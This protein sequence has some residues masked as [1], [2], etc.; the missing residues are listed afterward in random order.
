MSPLAPLFVDE[1]TKRRQ[2]IASDPGTSV[3]VSANAGSG[4]THVLTER[5]VRLLLS[6]VD[7]SKILC[8]T[9]T[10]AAAAEMSARVFAR[11]GEWATMPDE[12]LAGALERLDARRPP[13]AA[14]L[15]EARQLFARALET[16]GGLKIQTI[17]AFCEAI[18]HQFP[19][20]ADVPGHFE[21][22]DDAESARLL[23]ETRKRLLTGSAH[24]PGH[25]AKNL[26]EAFAEALEVAGEFGLDK[27][28]ADIAFKRD[29]VFRHL[30]E[31]GGL[32][33]AIARLARALAIGE[34][35][36]PA[37]TLAEAL[38]CPHLDPAT[39]DVLRIATLAS[40]AA[41]DAKFADRLASFRDDK[42][43]P[44]DRF[45]AYR[46]IG[47]DSKGEVRSS[48]NR[49]VTK[50]VAEFIPDLLERVQAAGERAKAIDERRATLR[51][52][53]ASRAALTIADA[54]ERE[55]AA[56]K[57]R[58]GR[59]DFTDLIA[60]T[61]DLLLRSEA[62]AW[63]H[64]KLDQGIDHILID[65]AQD[66]S[67]RQWQ[68]M[69][70]LAE[71]FFAGTGS[72]NRRR[73]LFAV[74]DEKQS[75]YS[76]QGASPQ[77]FDDERRRVERR[78][79]EAELAFEAIQLNRSFRTVETVLSAVDQ[80][81]AD[82]DNRKGLSASGEAPVHTAARR[83]GPGLVEIW[84]PFQAVAQDEPEDWTLP[85]D[86]EPQ[87]SP[88]NRLATRI[89]DQIAA[90][91]GDPILV[92][93]ERRALNPGDVMVLVRKRSGFGAALAAALRDRHIAVAGTDR[94]AITDHI[95]IEDLMALGRVVANFDDDL[96]LA[97]VLKSPL[98][99]FSDDELMGLALSREGTMPLSLGLRL[100]AGEN[101]LDRL[102]E[103]VPDGSAAIALL[104]K[105]KA[106]IARLDT[107]RDRAGFQGVFE[108]YA[109]ILG[110]E[111]GRKALVARLGRDAGEVIDAFLDLALA[112][113]EAG[114]TGLD[115]FLAELSESPPT[116]KRELGH[117]RGE[118]R[119]L[120]VHASKGLEAPVVF[121]VDPGSAAFSASHGASLIAFDPM[122]G[123]RPGQA[124]GFLWCPSKALRN[125]A[126]EALK[127]TEK[128][129][130][131]DEYRRLLYVGMTRAADRL[132]IC[133]LAPQ[134][135]PN[136]ESWLQRAIGALQDQADAITDAGGE[137]IAWRI[138][139]AAGGDKLAPERQRPTA[140]PKLPLSMLAPEILP[141]R[142]LSPSLAGA[143][144]EILPEP[145]AEADETPPPHPSPVLSA[146]AIPSLAIRRGLA[147]HRM[148][149]FLPD[150]APEDRPRAARAILTALAHDLPVDE[151]EAL[152]RQVLA[153]MAEPAFAPIFAP[154]SR[155]EVAVAGDV[156]LAGRQFTVNGMIDRLAVTADAVLIVDYKTNRLAPRDLS[157]VPDAYVVQLALYR[158]LIQPLYLGKRVDAAL[159]FTEAPRLI[160]IA[161]ERL[162]AALAKRP[163]SNAASPTVSTAKTQRPTNGDLA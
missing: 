59:L 26:A 92:K 160:A 126:V 33:E 61:A 21:V 28:L 128:A 24:M 64:Y 154:G 144:A 132:V 122:P 63:V 143:A 88:A 115:A 95:A 120:T 100:L 124:P 96:S 94:L 163:A 20:E 101:G 118:V 65:E 125:N 103:V 19:L 55:Y 10:K 152:M 74:G 148:L 2:A 135:G 44:E 22:M 157:A 105:A 15:A 70:E 108:F 136:P 114:V 38:A 29:E 71:E 79:G 107:L 141:P 93:G 123:L 41:T 159:I 113:E 83:D 62:S 18:L 129:R 130:A 11:L 40:K 80:V 106:A 51:L 156:T 56:L 67:P 109:R 45:A 27:L 133:G 87:T 140:M 58:R 150:L 158:A 46:A 35:D 34:G 17:H 66:T 104:E 76:F 37:A 31:A 146:A 3:F 147:A 149:E 6:G 119:I 50:A 1:D 91:L 110:P 155:A 86:V 138:G 9:F 52:F 99:N 145:Q 32:D 161:P 127:H 23:A 12:A 85:L 131:E 48:L 30:E 117:G 151:G 77:M 4:K 53:G 97:A 54:F 142:P 162:D 111:G 68:V 60:Q 8:L 73:T 39:C 49:L 75:I 7:P 25:A 98:F 47:L 13:N 153:V 139:A 81:F 112:K 82:P 89:A 134:R 5:V 116:L 16:P 84:P 69:R 78:A 42:A 137:A 14:R 57:R 72:H 43:A 102:P 121:L 36:Q 90:W